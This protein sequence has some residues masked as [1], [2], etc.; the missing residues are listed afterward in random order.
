MA[1]YGNSVATDCVQDRV[2]DGV[3]N[4]DSRPCSDRS[5]DPGLTRFRPF[6]PRYPLWPTV[7]RGRFGKSLADGF[8]SYKARWRASAAS[9]FAEEIRAGEGGGVSAWQWRECSD[10]NCGS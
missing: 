1:L 5:I 8:R 2:P 7:G 3:P 9:C 10:G 4:A 6:K